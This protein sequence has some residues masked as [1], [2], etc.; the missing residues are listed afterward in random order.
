M[1]DQSEKPE[2][3]SRLKK[4]EKE[5]GELQQSLR[6]GMVNVKVLMEFRHAV[7]H[8][9]QASAAMQH[10]L[11]EQDKAGGD[12]Y[13]LLPKVMT[14][15][16]RIATDLLRDVTHDVESGDLDFDTPGLV[17]FHQMLKTL[18]ERMTKFFPR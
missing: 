17:E 8:A 15:R 13:H 10:W 11:E 12:P 6:T 3:A 5:L 14:E 18:M 16:M 4:T 7:E 2:L 1:P 9:R